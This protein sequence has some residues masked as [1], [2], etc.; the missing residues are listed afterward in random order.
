MTTPN[1]TY[2]VLVREVYSQIYFVRAKSAKEAIARVA[3]AE[4]ELVDGTLCYSH[5][6]DPKGCPA[7]GIAPWE[8]KEKKEKRS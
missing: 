1:K 4:G 8:A 5:M 3:G 6:V 2:R 7:C